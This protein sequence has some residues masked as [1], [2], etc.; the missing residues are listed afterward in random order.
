MGR[1][2]VI[3]GNEINQNSD[4]FVVAEIG[5]NHMGKVDIA[6][7]MILSAKE[8]GAINPFKESDCKSMALL[9]KLL[10]IISVRVAK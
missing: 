7:K 10:F 2:F 3:D 6:D 9:T 4:C 5:A 8:A 1:K